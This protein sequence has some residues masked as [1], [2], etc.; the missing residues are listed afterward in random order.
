MVEAVL[1]IAATR[2]SSQLGS[3]HREAVYQR[4]LA[5]ELRAN[6]YVVSV[7]HP[8]PIT[9]TDS[10]GHVHPLATER[11]DLVVDNTAVIEIK[12]AE[13]TSAAA[14]DQA[15]RYGAA[16]SMAPFVVTFG[17]ASTTTAIN[18]T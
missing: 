1:R 5:A 6:G 18:R 16:L 9:Y 17:S 13:N 8:V 11:A 14:C 12:V 10:A 15:R 7:E 2:V 4:A 3:L